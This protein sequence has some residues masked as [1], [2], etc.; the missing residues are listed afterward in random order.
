MQLKNKSIIL[1]ITACVVWSTAFVGIK[2]GLRYTTP[3]H[4]AGIRFFL[5]G[6]FILPFC[7]NYIQNFRVIWQNRWAVLK[8]SFF[9]TFTLYSLFHLG[10]SKVSASVTA[11]IIGASPLFVALFARLLNNEALTKRKIVAILT[12]FSGIAIIAIGRFGG[13]MS[14][15]VSLLGIGI[16]LLANISGSLGNIFIAK[17]KVGI[18]PVFLNS[19]QLMV[20]GLGILILSLIFETGHLNP[21]PVEYYFALLWLSLIGSIGFSLWFIVLKIPGIK[22]SE[23]NVWK[24]IIPVLGA[25]LSWVMLPDEYPE[26]IVVAGMILVGLSLVVMYAGRKKS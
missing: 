20:G 12:G 4:L 19:V 1:A 5:A 8:I 25:I 7:K 21:K 26:L 9:S 6:L 22:V 15:E 16:L 23:I 17:N 18:H 3:L 14:L 24:F 10:I 11:L 13:L 2:I